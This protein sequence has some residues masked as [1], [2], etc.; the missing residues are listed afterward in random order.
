MR[1][2]R[3][4]TILRH[5]S[6]VVTN[7]YGDKVR[8]EY[9]Y[10]ISYKRW[11]LFWRHL[12]FYPE[13]QKSVFSSGEVEVLAFP[14]SIGATHFSEEADAIRVINDMLAHP[15]KYVFTKL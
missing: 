6:A 7:V 8:E 1:A 12:R 11:G 10:T 2:M 9:C 13:R 15:N 14:I 4:F 5:K 3:K